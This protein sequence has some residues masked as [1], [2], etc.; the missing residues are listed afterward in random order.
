[1]AKT[2]QQI[3]GST[4]LTGVV[5]GVKGGVPSDILPPA[6]M[7]ATR[8]VTGDSAKYRKVNNT[9]KVAKIVQYGSPS[10]RREQIGISEVPVKLLHT[11]E[12]EVFDA[13]TLQNLTSENDQI[14]R[15]GEAEVARQSAE[16]KRY[17]TNL[18]LAATYSM[19]AKGVIYFDADGNLLPSSSGAAITVDAQVSA[20]NKNQLNGVISAAWS[21]AGTDIPLQI[22]A[23]KKVARKLTGYKL[24]HAFH[25][26]NIL[27][28]FTTNTKMKEIINRNPAMQNAVLMNNEIPNGLL[29][30]NWIPMYEA[31]YEDNDGT[32]QDLVDADNV[33]FT[34]DPTPDW[35][36]V[37]EGTYAVP[38]DLVIGTD[39]MDVLSNLVQRP[40][41]FSYA[42]LK[43]DPPSIKQLAGDTFLPIIKVPDAIFI[44]TVAGF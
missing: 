39:A 19:L 34:P 4:T 8:V 32:D 38:N 22:A 33:I 43:T 6:F 20:N 13:A 35:W 11:F 10:K 7:R 26:E 27:G 18:R 9:R 36:E 21:A 12:H 40:G 41:M 15:L 3:L 1:M 17:F 14:Q 44:A 29:N 23:L 31:F 37:M 24:T 16:F 30:L 25:G 5:Q 28:Y 2:L 42:E